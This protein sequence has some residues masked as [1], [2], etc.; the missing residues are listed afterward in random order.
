MAKTAE[1]A[2]Q[3]RQLHDRFGSTER[4]NRMLKDQRQS[5]LEELQSRRGSE[6][7]QQS[8]YAVNSITPQ[9]H[10][11]VITDG[12]VRIV[13]LLN[14]EK[15]SGDRSATVEGHNLETKA[16]R[17]KVKVYLGDET[18]AVIIMSW[19]PVIGNMTPFWRHCIRGFKESVSIQPPLSAAMTD[20]SDIEQSN[21]P[22]TTQS[23][24]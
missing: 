22:R 12:A 17:V 23:I 16:L 20:R 1:L 18:V 8:S 10:M 14:S 7:K 13:A 9:K 5:H 4:Q 15:K 11:S 6:D 24:G 19:Y 21:H 2:N 3:M